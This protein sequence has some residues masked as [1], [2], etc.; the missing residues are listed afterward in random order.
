MGI[1]LVIALIPNIGDVQNTLVIYIATF[2]LYIFLSFS[3]RY[4]S[5]TLS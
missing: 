2:L 4:A 1:R 3:S 5:S